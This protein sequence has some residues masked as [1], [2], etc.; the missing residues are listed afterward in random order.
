MQ[1]TILIRAN[2]KLI[3]QRWLLAQRKARGA[4]FLMAYLTEQMEPRLK[5]LGFTCEIHA[6]PIETG[7]PIL[8][9]ARI[10]DP[11]LPTILT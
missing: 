9:A 8:T 5:S 10:E 7:P 11:A 4:P 6:N 1:K 2:S 3:L